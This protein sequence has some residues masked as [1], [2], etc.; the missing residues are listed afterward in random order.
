MG[1][2]GRARLVGTAA[3]AAVG[4]GV[5][6]NGAAFGPPAPRGTR[7]ARRA[8]RGVGAGSRARGATGGFGAR[9]ARE[10]LARPGEWE[11]AAGVGDGRGPPPTLGPGP[12][13][14][15]RVAWKGTTRP[16]HS[17]AA[18]REARAGGGREEE[19]VGGPKEEVGGGPGIPGLGRRRR[20]HPGARR[21][22]G[23]GWG[24][25]GPGGE[26]ETR[27]WAARGG[28]RAG[29]PSALRSSGTSASDDLGTEPLGPG[30]GCR[31]GRGGGRDRPR[32]EGVPWVSPCPG[33]HIVSRRRL[34][35]FGPPISTGT[36]LPQTTRG[37]SPLANPCPKS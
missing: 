18:R 20:T 11:S 9:P 23:D 6:T 1:A 34:Q 8:L 26:A 21:S 30:C 5:V 19:A 35:V 7:G 15:A 10:P 2:A 27:P 28:A 29:R 33:P 22:A 12:R 16:L 36:S 25:A 13:P 32:G 31:P 37:G 24:E 4:P 14:L 17:D 3:L